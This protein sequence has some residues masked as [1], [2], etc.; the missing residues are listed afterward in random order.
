MDK[1]SP[2]WNNK[3]MNLTTAVTQPTGADSAAA[4]AQIRAAA[5]PRPG[6]RLLDSSRTATAGIAARPMLGAALLA[7]ALW[8]VPSWTQAPAESTLL[9]A[10]LLL[11]AWRDIRQGRR[12]QETRLLHTLQTSTDP[13]QGAQHTRLKI[14]Q[15]VGGF[16]LSRCCALELRDHR[17]QRRLYRLFAGATEVQALALKPGQSAA[18]LLPAGP[19]LQAVLKTGPANGED[20]GRLYLIQARARRRTDGCFLQELAGLAALLLERAEHNDRLQAHSGQRGHQRL[21][22][23][24]H[25]SVIQPYIGLRLAL[26][27]LRMQAAAGLPIM[28]GLERVGAMCNSAIADLRRCARELEQPQADAA[29]LLAQLA[30]QAQHLR[31]FH[32]LEISVRA[33]GLVELGEGLR[34]EVMHMVREGLSNICRHTLA[35][36]GQVRLDCDGRWLKICIT[37]EGLPAGGSFTPRSICRRA[38]A[39]GGRALV[40]TEAGGQTAVHIELPL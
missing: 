39:L 19:R 1:M 33:S 35:R 3:K 37:N 4:A 12:L 23:D 22:L 27:A 34:T 31:Q 38:S 20:L 40:R 14:L 11:A 8:V 29:P 17:G 9:T 21:A 2:A 5:A 24:L 15:C 36:S 18:E 25:D 6:R 32:G 28:P 7:L 26:D 30:Q 13:R 10:A 16:F